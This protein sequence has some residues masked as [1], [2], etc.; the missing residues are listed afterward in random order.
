MWCF[1]D[2]GAVVGNQNY[3][4]NF[5]DYNSPNYRVNKTQLFLKFQYLIKS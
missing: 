1:G 2:G 3:I 5:V 4:D